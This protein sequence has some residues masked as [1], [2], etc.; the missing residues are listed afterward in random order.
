LTRAV[1]E[2]AAFFIAPF[3]AYVLYLI[4]RRR[5]PLSVEHWTHGWLA[6]LTMAG[7]AA[8]VAGAL[9]LGV[10]AERHTGTYVPAHVVDGKVVPGR[11]VD[12]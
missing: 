8:A 10:T 9:L 1:F 3:L 11:W 6:G 2:V 12:K 5:N 4:A 7:L